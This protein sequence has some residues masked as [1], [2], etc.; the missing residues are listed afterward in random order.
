VASL[1]CF[2]AR[3]IGQP[4]LGDVLVRPRIDRGIVMESING[5]GQIDTLRKMLAADAEAARKDFARQNPWKAGAN[6]E[7]LVDYG[8]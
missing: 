2:L 5:D 6:A 3:L 8:V 7:S 1:D 4:A